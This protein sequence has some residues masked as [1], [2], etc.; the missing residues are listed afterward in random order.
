MI[1]MVPFIL[2]HMIRLFILC[3]DAFCVISVQLPLAANDQTRLLEHN[4]Q[5]ITKWPTWGIPL[6][7]L[8]GMSCFIGS[9]RNFTRH[10]PAF[11]FDWSSNSGNLHHACVVSRTA[12]WWD[13]LA[14]VA[15]CN[16]TRTHK[17]L[18]AGHL[19][20]KCINGDICQPMCY[21]P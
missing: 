13:V 3:N 20:L 1:Y 9:V 10:R 5:S 21:V 7:A 14:A 17:F 12:L 19:K 6:I 16:S 18:S 2:Q 4:H 11:S 15:T 8:N